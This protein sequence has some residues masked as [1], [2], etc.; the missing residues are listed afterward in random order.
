MT[1]VDKEIS[2]VN[3][4]YSRAYAIYGATF[5]G[6]SLAAWQ[7]VQRFS[8]GGLALM[9]SGLVAYTVTARLALARLA[10]RRAQLV[11]ALETGSQ[12]P[13]DEIKA[14]TV[15]DLR[16][17]FNDALEAV[18]APPAPRARIVNPRTPIK[19]D[20]TAGT[21]E[22]LI[23]DVNAT[24]Q[25]DVERTVKRHGETRLVRIAKREGVVSQDEIKKS[26]S[27]TA[28]GVE[29]LALQGGRE[30]DAKIIQLNKRVLGYVRV[31]N[32]VDGDNPCPFCAML[33]SRG[34]DYKSKAS[35][36]GTWDEASQEMKK[37]H[38]NCHCTA[39]PVYSLEKFNSDPAY[40]LNRRLAQEWQQN[41]S[42]NY[43]GDEML[44]AWREHMKSVFTDGGRHDAAE[45][46]DHAVQEA[47]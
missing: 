9:N 37:Y 45:T 32:A 39:E 5:V 29:R 24:T 7:G 14:R 25:T 1:P 35:A 28:S 15:Q 23:E 34:F 10:L 13:G 44:P 41:I 47:A 16:D 2:A 22:G 27:L 43:S 33:M 12:L 30:T 6:Q 42:T 21:V 11:H 31:H 20:V 4:A 8:P 46:D 38:Y 19:L 18:G 26:K 3:A 17:A 36:S 40:E